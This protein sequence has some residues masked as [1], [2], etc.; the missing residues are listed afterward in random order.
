MFK[1]RLL[2]PGPSQVPEDTLLELARPVLYH[3]TPE[4]KAILKDVLDG[5]KYVFRTQHDV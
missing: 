3:R 4:A 2:T 1:P 5:L